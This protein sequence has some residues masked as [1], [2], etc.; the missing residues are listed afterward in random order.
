M[1]KSDNWQT[2][3]DLIK[4]LRQR[5]SF[6]HEIC[7]AADNRAMP[8]LPYMGLDNGFDALEHT[9]P[10]GTHYCNPPYS[11][12]PAFVAR[13]NLTAAMGSKV[14]LLIPAYTDTKYWQDII[15]GSAQDVYFL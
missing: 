12:L 13:A 1:G 14:I 6:S 11:K 15:D 9:W 4:V 10:P 7:A 2:P 5:Y 8:D 3:P